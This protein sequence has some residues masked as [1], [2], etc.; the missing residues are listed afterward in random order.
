MQRGYVHGMSDQASLD[1]VDGEGT[2]VCVMSDDGIMPMRGVLA[3]SLFYFC[4][5]G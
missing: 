4:P 3:V 1:L 2:R 5:D